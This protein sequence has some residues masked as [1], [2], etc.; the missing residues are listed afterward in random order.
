MELNSNQ[1]KAVE[2]FR[3]LV[4]EAE[5]N[6]SKFKII[7]QKINNGE[8]VPLEYTGKNDNSHHMSFYGL[9]RSCS[10][11]YSLDRPEFEQV[12]FLAQEK[13]CWL[14][15]VNLSELELV[16]GYKT[17]YVRKSNNGTK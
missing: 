11:V 15:P 16:P 1:I 3:K 5:E 7:Y 2:H 4:S 14:K 17:P 9:L 12:F 8:I 6:D 13:N 10:F